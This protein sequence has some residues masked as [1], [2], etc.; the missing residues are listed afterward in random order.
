M[1]AW[2]VREEIEPIDVAAY[3]RAVAALITSLRA[4]IDRYYRTSCPQYGELMDFCYVWLRRL[5]G[6]EA[7]GFDRPSSHSP[8][9]LTGNTTRDK[10][11]AHFTEGL[12]TVY[13]RMARALK[14]GA[15]LAFTCHHNKID[16]CCAVGVAILDAGMVCSASLPCPAEMGGSIHIHGTTSSII[17]TVFVCR[18]SGAAPI[19]WLFDKPERLGAACPHRQGA[20]LR[21]HAVYPPRPS[22]P[23]GDLDAAG[24]LGAISPDEREARGYPRPDD[25]SR[26]TR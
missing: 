19:D 7:A 16:A 20:H 25:C 8:R 24:R 23:D 12:A 14:P 22:E 13:S 6:S 10:N 3:E 2:I 9:E 1:S 26:G 11:L 21:R 5:A 15:P 18:R 4:D 17:D